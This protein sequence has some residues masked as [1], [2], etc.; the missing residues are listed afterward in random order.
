LFRKAE[1]AKMTKA[2][3]EE[4]E[5]SLKRYRNMTSLIEEVAVKDKT[6]AAKDKENAALKKE[7]AAYQKEKAAWEKEKADMRRQLQVYEA[8]I[9]FKSST[10]TAR[11]R[12]KR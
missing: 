4:Y 2:Q 7:N 11:S 6:I 5:H 1:I 10:G 9:S 3:R 12:S 8:N